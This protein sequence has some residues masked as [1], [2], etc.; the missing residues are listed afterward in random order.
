MKP[1]TQGKHYLIRGRVQGVGYRWFAARVAERLGVRGYARNLPCGDVEV[2][3]EAEASVL[4]AFREELRRGPHAAHVV[5]LVERDVPVTNAY[6]S[7][8]IG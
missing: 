3:A 7:F 6:N 8:F 4:Q 1:G 5:E 2:H